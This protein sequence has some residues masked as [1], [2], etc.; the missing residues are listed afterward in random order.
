ME[1]KHSS[2]EILEVTC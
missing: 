1:S 2:K